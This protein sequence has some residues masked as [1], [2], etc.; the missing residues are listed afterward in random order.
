VR[1][2][3]NTNTTTNNDN[4][5]KSSSSNNNN[6][7]TCNHL[8]NREP[9]L[10]QLDH[11]IE[12]L[13][14][15]LYG[16]RLQ[17]EAESGWWYSQQLTCQSSNSSSGSND[18]WSFSSYDYNYSAAAAASTTTCN[19]F[20]LA[21]DPWLPVGPQGNEALPAAVAQ[22]YFDLFRNNSDAV[23]FRITSGSFSARCVGMAA[24]AVVVVVG[25][26]VCRRRW[27]K[28]R[29][30]GREGG[31]AKIQ[32]ET[33]RERESERR[34]GVGDRERLL[35]SLCCVPLPHR[36]CPCNDDV[37]SS[38]VRSSS[39]QFGF[40]FHLC[41][42]TRPRPC[43]RRCVVQVDAT[44]WVA[45]QA[46]DMRADIGDV[47]PD[48]RGNSVLL[49]HVNEYVYNDTDLQAS[50]WV[51]TERRERESLHLCNGE[52]CGMQLTL[53][54][55]LCAPDHQLFPRSAAAAAAPPPGGPA[56]RPYH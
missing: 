54:A 41:F 44:D 42:S 20:G 25:V 31:R 8:H 33:D 46:A 9:T 38:H 48:E 45:R 15:A 37:H 50:V 1:L 27:R 26:G 22:L 21:T 51:G 13:A 28:S 2:N 17:A 47:F 29:L 55:P 7:N 36:V 30:H 16:Q 11:S 3:N 40:H 43:P 23:L 4:N 5:S 32:K 53:Q 52:P 12:T 34:E 6:N 19:D 56:L 10:L 35:L 18:S 39:I 14:S 49:R 24:K